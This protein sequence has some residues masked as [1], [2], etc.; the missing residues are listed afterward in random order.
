MSIKRWKLTVKSDGRTHE[1][2]VKTDTLTMAAWSL[3]NM[4]RDL[5]DSGAFRAGTEVDASVRPAAE[6]SK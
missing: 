4:L 1:R 3:Q 5:E 2:V 6:E